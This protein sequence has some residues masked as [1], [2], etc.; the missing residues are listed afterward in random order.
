MGDGIGIIRPGIID[1][2]EHDFIAAIIL[3]HFLFLTYNYQKANEKITRENEYLDEMSQKRLM[4][5]W[6]IKTYKEIGE[7]TQTFLG[8]KG[9][10]RPLN[11]LINGGWVE[12]MVSRKYNRNTYKYRVAMD[13]LE[14]DLNEIGYMIGEQNRVHKIKEKIKKPEIKKQEPKQENEMDLLISKFTNLD[15]KNPGLYALT[16]REKEKFIELKNDRAIDYI[17]YA[18]VTTKERQTLDIKTKANSNSIAKVIISFFK[19]FKRLL[20]EEEIKTIDVKIKIEKTSPIVFYKAIKKAVN[21]GCG[22]VIN[23]LDPYIADVKEEIIA[24]KLANAN[25]NKPKLKIY[26]NKKEQINKKKTTVFGEEYDKYQGIH[27]DD[28]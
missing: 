5:L 15:K 24:E 22:G 20:S 3:N 4:D 21:D 17:K 23:D 27:L 2:T 26:R 28:F 13:K 7:E 19:A 11:I 16:S 18:F 10:K 25:N 6:I 9:I 14:E 12:Q 8:E 1:I